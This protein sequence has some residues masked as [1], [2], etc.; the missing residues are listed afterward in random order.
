MDFLGAV[1][2]AIPGG[3]SITTLPPE[4]WDPVSFTPDRVVGGKK[5][6]KV[7]SHGIGLNTIHAWSYWTFK[8]DDDGTV[9]TVWGVQDL[10]GQEH[11][12]VANGEHDLTNMGV[13]KT[14]GRIAIRAIVQGLSFKVS[15]ELL[16]DENGKTAVYRMDGRSFP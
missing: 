7:T 2:S 16:Y 12:F 1:K 11:V 13:E 9:H 10:T 5:I 3:G 4:R 14:N 15:I 6:G 8:R